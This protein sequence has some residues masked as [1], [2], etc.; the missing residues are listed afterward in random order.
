MLCSLSISTHTPLARRDLSNADYLTNTT[1]I[2]THTPL[3]RRDSPPVSCLTKPSLFLL[4]RLSRGVT[5]YWT[6]LHDRPNIST[7]TPLARR[8]FGVFGE[9]ESYKKISTHTPLARRDADLSARTRILTFLLTRL[10]GSVT[11]QIGKL[12]RD[13]IIS[14]HT[15]LA[16]RDC[17]P[18]LCHSRK[19][20]S[21]HTPLAR[22]DLMIWGLKPMITNFYSHASREA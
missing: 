16:R 22:R 10:S 1:V 4:T 21:T 18:I 11:K 17:R 2:S 5:K 12:R 13:F 14:T 8:D 7:H 20:I 19:Q 3:A 15:P 6:M 9:N